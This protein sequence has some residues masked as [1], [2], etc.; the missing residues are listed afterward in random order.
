[1]V[2]I[3]L[4]RTAARRTF[5]ARR[6]LALLKTWQRRMRDRRALATMDERSLRDLGLSRYDAFY[7]ARKPFWRA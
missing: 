6:L 3:A 2:A 7:E 5:R 1:M 4:H